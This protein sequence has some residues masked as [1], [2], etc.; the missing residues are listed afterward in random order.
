VVANDA[1]RALIEPV[2]FSRLVDFRR[3]VRRGN[4]TAE[5]KVATDAL[6]ANYKP[7]TEYPRKKKG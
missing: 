6:L 1:E 2:V 3:N 7:T 4:I 5:E